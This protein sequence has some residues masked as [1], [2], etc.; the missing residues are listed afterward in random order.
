MGE[1]V[2][3]C[4]GGDNML[5]LPFNLVGGGKAQVHNKKKYNK[6][7]RAAPGGWSVLK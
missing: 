1:P 3:V 2:C 6:M 7:S 4:G 5:E